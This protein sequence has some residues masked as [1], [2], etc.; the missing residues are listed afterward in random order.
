MKAKRQFT[1]K[2]KLAILESAEGIGIKKAADLAGVHYTSVYEWRQ[3]LD[4]VGKDGFLAYR[5]PSR[6]RGIKRITAE[7]ERAVLETWQRYRG[8]GPSQVRNQL[9]RQGITISTRSVQRIMKANGYEG[10]RK[11]PKDNTS[12]RFEASRPLELVQIDIVEFF[13]HKLKVYLIL[14]LD[15]FSRFILGFRLLEEP[16]IDGLIQLV[17]EVIDRYGKMEEILSDRGFVFYSWRGANRFERFLELEG[18]DHTHARAHHPQTLGKIEAANK[19]LQKELLRR[20]QFATMAQALAALSQWVETF[21][22][23]RTHQGLG[24]FLVPADRFHGRVED[25]LKS[26]CEGLDPDGQSCYSLAGV[27]RSLINLILEP[28]RGV[29]LYILGR[30]I[31]LFGGGHE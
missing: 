28:E 12:E 2:Q 26:I 4:V 19:Q 15:D 10:L 16:S 5:P 3:K 25:V 17:R 13:I 22:Y 31:K 20:E 30:P 27:S 7:Q 21:N 8:F 11:K 23:R 29:F 24:G 6:G 18:I 1:Q 14:F 9:R